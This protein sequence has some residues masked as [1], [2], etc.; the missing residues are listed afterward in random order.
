MQKTPIQTVLSG[1]F[2][3]DSA[4]QDTPW[5]G[6]KYSPART[7]R[8]VLRNMNLLVLLWRDDLAGWKRGLILIALALN[9]RVPNTS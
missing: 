4:I 1:D 2:F 8:A 3:P 7:G 6:L 9:P 5:Q